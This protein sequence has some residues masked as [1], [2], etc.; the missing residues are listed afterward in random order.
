MTGVTALTTYLGLTKFLRGNAVKDTDLGDNL[1]AIDAE[2]SRLNDADSAGI[3]VL[4]GDLT[5]GI[6]DAFAFAVQ[7]P[8]SVACHVLQIVIDITTAG[9]TATA[10]LDVDVVASATDTGDT[11]LDGLDLNADAIY[12]SLSAGVSG[13]NADENAHRWDAAEG[14]NDYITGKILV[15]T[16]ALMV[17]TYTI[18][19]VKV[20]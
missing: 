6:A 4:K 11:I 17:G 9:G 16:A 5:A 19:Y 15:E 20:V 1:D 12:S 8:E 3:K 13:T 7:N 10:V 14:A 18:Y 2:L